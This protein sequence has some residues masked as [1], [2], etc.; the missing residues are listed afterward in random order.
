MSKP[1]PVTHSIPDSMGVS[2]ETKHGNIVISGDLKLEH[3]DGVPSAK[4]KN[5]W[6]G[7]GKDKNILFIG[8]STN[9]ERDGF[10]IPEG[11]CTHE[12]RK[13]YS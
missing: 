5:T 8:D 11:A 6:G 1:F 4:E 9:A 3:E 2:V 13:H 12:H 10:S 7:L